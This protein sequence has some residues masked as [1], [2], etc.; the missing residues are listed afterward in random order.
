MSP[1]NILFKL[2]NG[3]TFEIMDWKY[4]PKQEVADV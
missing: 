1:E 3:S 4:V 2:A